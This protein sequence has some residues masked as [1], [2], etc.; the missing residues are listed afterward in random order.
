MGEGRP[1]VARET[2][3][4]MRRACRG[5]HCNG[6]DGFFV[7]LFLG[8]KSIFSYLPQVGHIVI[9]LGDICLLV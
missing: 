5:S 8:V 1:P 6:K 4:R 3:H 2:F 7:V 9:T